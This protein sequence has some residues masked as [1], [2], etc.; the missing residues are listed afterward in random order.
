MYFSAST[1]GFY[2]SPKNYKDFPGDAIEISS[3][4]YADVVTNR[5]LDKVLVVD[6]NGFPALVNKPPATPEQIAAE[7]DALRAEAYRN[8]ADPLFFKAERGEVP[9]DDWLA[10]VAEIKARYPK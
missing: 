9:V 4:L 6:A 3:E 10:K 5:P 8:E 2:D 1:G 7:V